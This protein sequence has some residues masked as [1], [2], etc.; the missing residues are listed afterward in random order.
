LR[1]DG[2]TRS[3]DDKAKE[4]AVAH[5]DDRRRLLLDFGHV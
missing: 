2:Q 3:V 1:H 5:S 4:V